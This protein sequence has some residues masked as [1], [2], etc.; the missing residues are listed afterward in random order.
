MKIK[1]ATSVQQQIAI[2]KERGMSI[3][4]EEKAKEIL[5][6]IGYYR[7]GFYWFP[8]EKTYPDKRNRTHI[9]RPGARFEDAVALYYF[10]HDLRRSLTDCLHRIE[11]H[12]RTRL[13]YIV[14][15]YYKTNPTWFSDSSVI[16][17]AFLAKLP[18][19]YD[20]IRKNDA[21]KHHHVKYSKDLYA[22]AWKTLEFMTFGSILYLIENLKDHE[23]QQKIANSMGIHNLDVFRSQMQT[24]R[25]LRN[26]CAHGHNLF[27]FDLPKSIKPG[28]IKGM[29][30]QQRNST[31]GA[32]IVASYVL[33]QISSNRRK[34]FVNEVN[35]LI[36]EARASKIGAFIGHLDLLAYE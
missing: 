8:F 14:S 15:N 33:G 9:F 23:L 27:D 25:I 7:L 13:I 4:D 10:D 30:Q 19:L 11:I 32:L 17:G 20:D 26:I 28:P 16:S 6:G 34:D 3:Y 18:S 5:L 1:A 24:L 29:S 35:K 21:I 2:L 31:A 22:P 12:L 36:I